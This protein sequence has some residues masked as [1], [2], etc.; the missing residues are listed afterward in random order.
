MALF[1]LIETLAGS[2]MFQTGQWCAARRFALSVG[3]TCAAALGDKI[4]E[5]AGA[6]QSLSF[7]VRGRGACAPAGDCLVPASPS[8]AHNTCQGCDLL[9]T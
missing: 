1:P 6:R 3:S 4:N 2:G 9:E 5:S 8:D 7:P